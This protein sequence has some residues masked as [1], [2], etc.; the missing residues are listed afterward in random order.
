MQNIAIFQFTQKYGPGV[1]LI[2]NIGSTTMVLY[3]GSFHFPQTYANY[4]PFVQTK[5]PRMYTSMAYL[6]GYG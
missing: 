1:I 2:S 3:L 6:M 5:P 4:E